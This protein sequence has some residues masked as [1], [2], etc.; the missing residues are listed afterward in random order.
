MRLGSGP[1][2]T[3]VDTI[4]IDFDAGVT[5]ERPARG[6]EVGPISIRALALGR[7]APG[8]VFLSMECH[9]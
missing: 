1:E 9:F 8:C 7:G 3:L 6:I 4:E 2:A 5:G